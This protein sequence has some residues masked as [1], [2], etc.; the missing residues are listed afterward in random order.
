MRDQVHPPMTLSTNLLDANPP[1]VLFVDD[2]PY[3]SPSGM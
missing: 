1:T 2:R 3:M